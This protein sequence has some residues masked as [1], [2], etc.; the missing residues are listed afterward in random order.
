MSIDNSPTTSDGDREQSIEGRLAELETIVDELQAE[1]EALREENEALRERVDEL[2]S[3]ATV[4]WS[5]P[6]PNELKI[7]DAT[8]TNTVYPYRA[9]SDKVRS[10]ELD[11]IEERLT[12]IE[13][14][15]ADVIVRS[16]T[17]EDALPIE[18]RIA[19]QHAGD[20]GL[21]A[22]EERAAIVFPTFGGRASTVGGSKLVM[23]SED[24]RHV[25]TE[26][27]NRSEWPAVTIR[28][29]MTWTARLTSRGGGEA[30]ARDEENLITLTKR[31]GRLA[32]EAERREWIEWSEDASERLGE[33]DGQA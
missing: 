1:N 18:S 15:R 8:N 13:E 30:D 23:S 33:G 12:D 32:L 17:N 21:T 5:S 27:T 29:V 14:G 2:E 26:K 4:E 22:N 6:N 28:R 10:E 7:T 3:Q 24:V 25:L 20:D 19:R 11:A 31:N 16:E 9:I